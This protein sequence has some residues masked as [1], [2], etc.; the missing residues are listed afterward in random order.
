[1]NFTVLDDNSIKCGKGCRSNPFN[2]SIISCHTCGYECEFKSDNDNKRIIISIN[3]SV[4]ICSF[5]GK[6]QNEV[7]KLVAGNKVYICDECIDLS[8][9]I[10]TGE[11]GEKE[12]IREIKSYTC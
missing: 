8:K 9:E 11:Y 4:L 2:N 6:S 3:K 10:I 1:M 5:C 7:D 12:L